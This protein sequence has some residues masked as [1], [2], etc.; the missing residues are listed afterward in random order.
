MTL[1]W[2]GAGQII[3]AENYAA[4]LR[5]VIGGRSINVHQG[6]H[7]QKGYLCTSDMVCS[8][9]NINIDFLLVGDLSSP[10]EHFTGVPIYSQA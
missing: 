4:D 8:D 7:P 10:A 5:C 3:S 1:R 9:W 2:F 6:Y